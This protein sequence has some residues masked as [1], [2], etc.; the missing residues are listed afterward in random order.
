MDSKSGQAGVPSQEAFWDRR[1]SGVQA[2]EGLSI[3][4][5]PQGGVGYEKG[6]SVSGG[7]AAGRSLLGQEFSPPVAS[8]HLEPC[9]FLPCSPLGLSRRGAGMQS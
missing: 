6:V 8:S 4:T 1:L 3:R 2:E 5:L 7:Q 9:S